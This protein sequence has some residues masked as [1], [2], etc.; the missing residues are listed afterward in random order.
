MKSKSQTR[1]A[2]RA[3]LASFVN[4]YTPNNKNVNTNKDTSL[5]NLREEKTSSNKFGKKLFEKKTRSLKKITSYSKK[6]VNVAPSRDELK[7]IKREIPNL[8]LN[9]EEI[10]ESIQVDYLQKYGKFPDINED[11]IPH[12]S[13]SIE[14]QNYTINDENND[15]AVQAIEKDGKKEELSYDG[16]MTEQIDQGDRKKQLSI[17]SIAS[18]LHDLNSYCRFWSKRQEALQDH[19]L[20]HGMNLKSGNSILV[21]KVKDC[22][23]N[24]QWMKK[25]SPM[26]P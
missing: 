21:V 24:I 23:S 8:L 18:E 16:Q 10:A 1:R 7:W 5:D 9:D 4:T 17:Y 19:L 6:N 3:S 14:S 12:Y 20:K 22:S 25:L 11:R 15:N 13:S 2:R 26:V